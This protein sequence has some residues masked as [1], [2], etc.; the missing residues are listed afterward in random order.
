MK[1]NRV[2]TIAGSDSGGGA[3]I[4]ADIKAISAC[5]CFATSAITAV[6]AQN[7]LGVEAVEGLSTAIIEQQI[8]AVLSDIGTDSVKIGML[9]SADVVRTVAATLRRFG[10]D[11]V[12]LDPVMVSTSGHRLIEES[13]VDVL[14]SELIPMARIITPNIP[15]AEILL[16]APIPSQDGMPDAARE[17]A[18]R[19]GARRLVL[20]GSRA[21]GDHRYNS[22][23]DLAVYGM[24]EENEGAFG[25][26]CD[27]LPTLLKLDIVQI[28]EGMNPA[29]LANIEKDGVTLMDRLHEK[30]EQFEA[31]VSRLREALEDYRSTPLSS[32]RDGVIQRFE[33]CAELAWKTMR[34]YLLDQGYTEINS[35]KAVIRQA[36]AYGMIEDADGWVRLMNDRNLNSFSGRET[37]VYYRNQG[38]ARS[39]CGRV[40]CGKEYF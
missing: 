13:A 10:V 35:P 2:L 25:M 27:E 33:F 14:R 39:G 1:Y 28:R 29:F 22:D 26:D 16:D 15:E 32:V 19:Y 17:L 38:P 18:R 8:A 7:T 30:Y 11:N 24:P 20:Y 40:L 31:A 12:V 5:G 37:V 34:E 21:R 6:T 23:V 9:H 4:Q 3:G 36:F